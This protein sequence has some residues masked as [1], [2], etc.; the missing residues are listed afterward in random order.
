MKAIEATGTQLVGISYDR[1]EVLRDF[2][3]SKHIHFPLLSDTGSAT[4]K[5]YG[6]YHQDGLPHPGT[7]V[8]D[9]QGIV[10]A[11]LFVEGYKTRHTVPE[12]LQALRSVH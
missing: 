2:A 8:I 6:I 11:A 10:R 4:I 1:V 9:Q 12:L 5:A 7:F 3:E